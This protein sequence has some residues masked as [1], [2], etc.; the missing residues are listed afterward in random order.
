MTTHISSPQEPVAPQFYSRIAT[1]QDL[2]GIVT[3]INRAF[4]DENPYLLAD[5]TDLDEIRGFM[6]KGHFLLREEEGKLIALIY[7]EIRGQSR[8]YLGLLVVESTKRRQGI[9]KQLLLA[10][11]DFCRQHGCPVR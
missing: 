2:D 5:R 3:L 8:A 6:Q 7:A 4:A 1:A 9:G 10:G 11:E